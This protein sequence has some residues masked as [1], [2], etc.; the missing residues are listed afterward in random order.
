MWNTENRSTV[1]GLPPILWMCQYSALL[2]HDRHD[3]L[4]DL[5]QNATPFGG[6]IAA[7]PNA[8]SL[9]TRVPTGTSNNG[10]NWY[11][12]I[13]GQHALTS[14]STD[15]IQRRATSRRRLLP[16]TLRLWQMLWRVSLYGYQISNQPHHAPPGDVYIYIPA[17]MW[18]DFKDQRQ[19]PRRI[20]IPR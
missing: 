5:F 19:L 17:D 7:N 20:G 11:P 9:D 16:V 1:S 18:D 2:P 4:Y 6:A 12:T 14:D 3:T 10:V 13:E 15:G 8:Q